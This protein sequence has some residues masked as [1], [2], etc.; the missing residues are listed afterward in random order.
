MNSAQEEEFLLD[1]SR[2]ANAVESIALT[3]AGYAVSWSVGDVVV[4]Y[5]LNKHEEEECK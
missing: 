5:N 1:I 2:I 4:A 3:A